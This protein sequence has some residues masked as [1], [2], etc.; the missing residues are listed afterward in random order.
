MFSRL[1]IIEREIFNKA[2]NFPLK[3]NKLENRQIIHKTGKKVRDFWY[4]VYIYTRPRGGGGE[5]VY[6]KTLSC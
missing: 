1:V 5:R 6:I 2:I 3:E 4:V